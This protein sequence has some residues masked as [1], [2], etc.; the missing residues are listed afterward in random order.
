MRINLENR[1]N[2]IH[3]VFPFGE[4]SK[5]GFTWLEIN[6]N[7]TQCC[8]Y[9]LKIDKKFSKKL[10]CNHFLFL[11]LN[12]N[13]NKRICQKYERWDHT[14]TC[15]FALIY[16]ERMR[17]VVATWM[18]FDIDKSSVSFYLISDK[19]CDINIYFCMPTM[20]MMHITRSGIKQQFFHMT[21][22]RIYSS[23]I[24]WNVYLRFVIDLK[25]FICNSNVIYFV[26]ELLLVSFV[27]CLFI[28]MIIQR[29]S[30]RIN[31]DIMLELFS[32]YVAG[33]KNDT[34]IPW[35]SCF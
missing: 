18:L 11:Q 2:L 17:L 8:N 24:L 20:T 32:Y 19:M 3:Q 22:Y 10:F 27:Y 12:W 26:I 31:L 4:N 28:L 21:P 23:I 16:C 9:S 25:L 6:L 30:F 5:V 13:K 35:I 14:Q 15:H 33:N 29:Y 7:K 34:L 1:E